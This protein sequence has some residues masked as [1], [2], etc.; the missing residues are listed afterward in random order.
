MPNV[1]WQ[2]PLL[3][4]QPSGHVDGPHVNPA[5]SPPVHTP[6]GPHETHVP[7]AG[8]HAVELVPGWQTSFVSQQPFGHVLKLHAVGWQIPATHAAAHSW[9]WLAP[10]PQAFGSLPGWQAPFVSQHPVGHVDASQIEFSHVPWLQNPCGPHVAQAPPNSPHAWL[11]SPAWQTPVTSQHPFGQ[12]F[13]LHPEPTHPPPTHAEPIG[14]DTHAR[15]PVPQSLRLPPVTHAPV[16]SQ[17]PVGHVIG[18]H[19]PPLH[20]PPAHT[21]PGAQA[22]Q[23]TPPV[24]HAPDDWP[25]WHVPVTSQQPVGQVCESHVDVSHE[26]PTHWPAGPQS[27]Q[28]WPN[29]PHA[30]DDV[31]GWQLPKLSQQ[32]FGHVAGLHPPQLPPSHTSIAQPPPAQNPGAGQTKHWLPPWPHAIDVSPSWQLPDG[33]QQPWHEPGPH[34][35]IAWQAPPMH[36]IPGG[37]APHCRPP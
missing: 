32:P 6:P 34:S 10:V 20:T 24:P 8:P 29:D 21:A 15:P 14:H 26:P 17:Q 16:A 31:P 37:H 4:Q 2:S 33:S 18:L 27:K 5:H 3:S 30:P 36:W 22:A 11:V 35:L 28:L 7:P 13:A 25:G 23:N 9:H 19:D 1:V 12:L